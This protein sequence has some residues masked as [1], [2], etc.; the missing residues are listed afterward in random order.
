M[1]R[2]EKVC[3]RALEILSGTPYREYMEAVY[4]YGSCARGTQRYDS[5]VDLLVQYNHRFTPQIGRS[6]R[7][8][9]TPEDMDQPEVELK[10]V[11][12][13]SWKRRQDPFSANL[14]K[15]G[16]LLWKK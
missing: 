1:S 5:D 14:R 3:A 10:F 16:V 15:D 12:G 2:H 6:M 13:D 8:A 4:L 11:N 7:I 9:V